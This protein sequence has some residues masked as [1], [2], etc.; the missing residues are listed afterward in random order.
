MESANPFEAPLSGT[1]SMPQGSG[2]IDHFVDLPLPTT[3]PRVASPPAAVRA[4]SPQQQQPQSIASSFGNDGTATQHPYVT[5]SLHHQP[6]S[7]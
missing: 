5:P 2:P 6:S 1:A 7:W 3:T 4:F